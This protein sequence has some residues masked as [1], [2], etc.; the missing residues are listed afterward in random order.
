MAKDLK[1]LERELE[2]AEKQRDIEIHRE[3]RLACREK[4]VRKAEDR[5]RTHRLIQYGVA[6]E[7]NDE[8]LKALSDTE[9]FTLVEKLFSIPEVR[10]SLDEAVSA[11][12]S[13]TGGEA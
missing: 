4:Y 1:K 3:K 7:A 10:K 11:S 12:S 5:R 13:V 6:F 9:I 8:R 2:E